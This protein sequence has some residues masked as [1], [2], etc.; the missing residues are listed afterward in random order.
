MEERRSFLKRTGIVLLGLAGTT[1]ISPATGKGASPQK[2]PA[3]IIDINRCTGCHSCVIACKEQNITPTGYFNT[4]IETR[5]QGTYPSAWKIYTP[6][7]CHQCE[8]APCV[9]ACVNDATFQLRSGVVVVDWT[10]CQGD[11]DCLE[12]CPYNARFLDAQNGNKADK[13]DFCIDRLVKGL[14][15][16]CV[17]GCPSGARIFG[18][19][20]KPQGEFGE[21]LGR[22]EPE[23]KNG[24][25]LFF[26]SARKR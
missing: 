2:K 25:R 9:E 3:M 18:D 11:G 13:C 5:Q 26:T 10:L 16:A 20:V 15:P 7:L 4:R 6:A 19:L 8:D 24:T 21:Y 23:Q 12:A 17:E 22:L 14:E 1:A